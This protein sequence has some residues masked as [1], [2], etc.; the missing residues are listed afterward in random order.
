M[1]DTVWFPWGFPPR[2]SPSQLPRPPKEINWDP[3]PVIAKQMCFTSKIVAVKRI[4]RNRIVLKKESNW[5]IC[6]F[7][8]ICGPFVQILI[9]HRFYFSLSGL[10]MVVICRYTAR[11]YFFPFCHCN[12]SKS[13]G[14]CPILNESQVNK[15][16][17]L[18]KPMKLRASVHTKLF[19]NRKQYALRECLPHQTMQ[20][21]GSV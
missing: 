3:C 8:G 4:G 12:F 9:E 20:H 15:S 6:D 14:L 19:Q 17:C 16:L 11:W 21:I 2:P 5:L 10:D 7:G 1:K 13:S 18:K